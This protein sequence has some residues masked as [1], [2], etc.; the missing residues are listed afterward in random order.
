MFTCGVPIAIPA[1]L[2]YCATHGLN[3]PRWLVV[4]AAKMLCAHLSWNVPKERGR[5]CGIINRYRQDAI[6]RA[7]WEA[8]I[9]VRENRNYL[10]EDIETPRGLRGHKA[11]DILEETRKLLDW[12][13]TNNDDAFEC[14]SLIL[15]DTPAHGKP[16]AIRRSYLRVE[17]N[18]RTPA[19]AMRY[20]ILE[21]QFLRLVGVD[22]TRPIR[23][24]KKIVPLYDLTV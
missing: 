24:G 6:D 11:R 22:I 8:V 14:A 7:R 20:R 19:T 15:A 21:T 23:P 2:Y 10:R 13:G 4:E 16:D 17:K 18:M 12:A 3:A 5:S 9:E 1:A